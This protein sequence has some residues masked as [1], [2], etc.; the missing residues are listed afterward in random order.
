MTAFD[1]DDNQI[2]LND[3]P[4]QTEASDDEEEDFLDIHERVF[5][6]MGYQQT[7]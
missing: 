4:Q 5:K 7:K 3:N 6:R 1:E 2:Y